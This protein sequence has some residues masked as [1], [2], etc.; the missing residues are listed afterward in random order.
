MII[1]ECKGSILLS[2]SSIF[3][4]LTLLAYSSEYI[5]LANKP[6]RD[7]KGYGSVKWG[8]NILSLPEM[9]YLKSGKISVGE[10]KIYKNVVD[11]L[12][13]NGIKLNAIEY[14]FNDDKLVFVALKASGR[15]N[16]GAFKKVAIENFG[17]GFDR[18]DN[19]QYTNF[20]WQGPSSSIALE[21]NK[22]NGLIIMLLL[23]N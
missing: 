11:S 21:H 3:L 23:S 9:R 16:W 12:V 18:Y 1:R 6:I 7:P 4:F 20:I 13:Y 14:G 17:V 22:R 10:I 19:Q 2:F 15:E 8:D 5:A